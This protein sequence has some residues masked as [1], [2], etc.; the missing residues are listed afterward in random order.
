MSART[1]QGL[2]EWVDQLAT[3]PSRRARVVDVD[4]ELYGQAEAALGWLNATVDLVADQEFR[5]AVWGEAL[6][7]EVQVACLATAA[8]IAHVKIL[9]VTPDGSDRIG[10]TANAGRAIWDAGGNL[11][12]AREVSAIINARVAT[13]P[14]EL[15]RVVEHALQ[16][17]ARASGVRA[18]VL[19][20]ES[21][22]PAPP[23][24]PVL[25]PTT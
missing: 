21:F 15:Q 8:A 24:R 22:A 17:A 16:S 1:G 18:A 11:A 19:H 23:T 13:S 25:E 4:Y 5:P 7:N 3:A 10:L 12:P 6:I 9:L 14:E 20:M 2:N